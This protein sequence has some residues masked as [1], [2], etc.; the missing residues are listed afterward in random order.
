MIMNNKI[1]KISLTTLVLLAVSFSCVDESLYPLPYNDRTTGAYLR[2][3]NQTSNV[4]DLN[5][6]GNSA[7]EAVYEPVDEHGGDDLESVDF[8]VSHRRGTDLTEEVFLKTVDASVFTAV[9]EPTYSVYKRGLIKITANEILT[10]LQTITVDPDGDGITAPICSACVPLKGLSVFPG[11]YAAGDQV[12]IRYEM[13]MTDGRR[14]SVANAQSTVNPAFANN[15]TANSTPNITTGQFYNS[16]FNVIVTVRSLLAGSWVGDYSL[17]Q[18][19]LWSPNH[20]AQVHF[21]SFPGYLNEVLFPNQTVTLSYNPATM[22]ST[23][24]EFTV[25]YRGAT[26]TMRI[27]LENGTTWV[28]LRNSTVDCTSERE[29]YW[30]MPPTGNFAPA[31]YVLPAG[32]PQVTTNNRGAYSTAILGTTLGDVL[33]IGVDDDCDEYG[34]RNG[35]CTWVRRLR[36]TLTK[37]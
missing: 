20:S 22:L 13:V 36:L 12:N 27:N 21:E 25:Q 24:R 16:P 31:P 1:Y 5:D 8:F 26:T 15:A 23:E 4:F 32:L 35:Y 7:F 14:F 2:I 9:P 19:S 34:R 29:I 11:S 33:T 30:C 37:L 17:T 3:Y 18:T 10:A 28:P 6:L